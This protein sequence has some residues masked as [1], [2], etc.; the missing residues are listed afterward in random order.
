MLKDFFRG[1]GLAASMA[2]REHDKA[3]IQ[4]FACISAEFEAGRNTFGVFCVV[5]DATML[6]V[7]LLHYFPGCLIKECF[8]A[9]VKR[10]KHQGLPQVLHVLGLSHAVSLL[11]SF[12]NKSRNDVDH[13]VV[14]T[15]TGLGVALS[16]VTDNAEGRLIGCNANTFNR[17]WVAFGQ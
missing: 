8:L 17:I 11:E 3:T 5:F 9:V 4:D 10:G 1:D 12:A 16:G 14:G 2:T 13:G 15:L 7:D 6:E